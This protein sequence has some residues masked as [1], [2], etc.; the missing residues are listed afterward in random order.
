MEHLK[1]IYFVSCQLHHFPELSCRQN[2]YYLKFIYKIKYLALNKLV[3]LN[4]Q[5]PFLSGEVA[6]NNLEKSQ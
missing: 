3:N 4:R 2:I 1:I 6:T 5:W